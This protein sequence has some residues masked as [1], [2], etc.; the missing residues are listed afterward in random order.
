M[1][2]ME[3]YYVYLLKCW[4]NKDSMDKKRPLNGHVIYTGYTNNIFRRLTEHISCKRFNPK[5]PTFTS[6]FKGNIILGCLEAYESRK[7]AMN[8]ELKLKNK[9]KGQKIWYDREKKIKLIQ[10]FE[11]KHQDKIDFIMNQVNDLL[12]KKK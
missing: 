5:R 8:R 10:E 12:K 11:D 4:K 2:D 6:Q 3:T 9:I 1:I 7:V